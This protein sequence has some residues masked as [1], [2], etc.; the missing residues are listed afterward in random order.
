MSN[1]TAL[2]VAGYFIELAA[3]S[4]END[5][6]NLKLQK[7]L[8]FAQGKHLSQFDTP[9]FHDDIEAWKLGPVVR[10]VYS[11]YKKCGAFPITVF[12]GSPT[13]ASRNLPEP[14]KAFLKKR[15][16]DKYGKY[17]ASY[18]VSLSHKQGGPWRK[19]YKAETNATIPLDAL[20]AAGEE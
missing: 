9:L 11:E 15:V 10:A 19:F 5:L 20:K 6:T 4:D 16:W 13:S 18:L 3:E 2:S 7:L 14:I 8:Y 12:D 17:S 1:L